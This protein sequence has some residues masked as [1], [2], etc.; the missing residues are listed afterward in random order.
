MHRLRSLRVVTLL[1]LIAVPACGDD[2]EKAPPKSQP[3]EFDVPTPTPAEG[4]T[5][6]TDD[7][8]PREDPLATGGWNDDETGGEEPL[9]PPLDEGAFP[10]PC[11]ITWKDGPTVRLKYTDTGGT[12][13]IDDDADG[14]A[15]TCGKFERKDGVTTK[16]WI[17]LACDKSTDM[18]IVPEAM[19]EGA[20]N[21]LGAEVTTYGEGKPTKRAIT[22]LAIPGMSGIEPGYP[23]EVAKAAAKLKI[24]DG[25]VRRA[26]VPESE[27]GAATRINLVYDKDKRVKKLEEDVGADGKIDRK[28][29][30]KYDAKG[31][32]SKISAVLT[33]TDADGKA[34]TKKPTARLDYSCWKK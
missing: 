9:P 21:V 20:G 16:V 18:Q 15:D 2:G 12:V 13:R 33:A 32:V 14:T 22:L 24:E 34:V 19:V 1:A 28:Y 29:D 7:A 4:E 25:L 8:A 23:I 6:A 11:K 10:G 27:A 5:D 26:D 31:N 30:Y 3:R 17:D